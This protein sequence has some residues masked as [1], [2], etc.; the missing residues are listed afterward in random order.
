[1]FSVLLFDRNFNPIPH[2]FS[3]I[4]QRYGASAET[5]FDSAEIEVTGNTHQMQGLRHWLRY[6]VVIRNP[7]HNAVWA[8][9]VT[10]VSYPKGSKKYSLTLDDMSN[11]LAVAHSE[12]DADGNTLSG[13]T[14]YADNLESQ[15]KYGIKDLLKAGGDLDLAM[16]T[17]QRDNALLAIGEP[18][19]D[20]DLLGGG[21]EAGQLRCRG[22]GNAFAWRIFNQPGGV[23][24]HQEN[25]NF[26]HL[27][28]WGIVASETMAFGVGGGQKRLHRL[29]GAMEALRKDDVIIVSGA[30][31]GANNGTFT[32]AE[33]VS[34]EAQSYTGTDISSDPADDFMSASGGLGFVRSHELLLVS[35]FVAPHTGNNRYYF[36]HTE[37]GAGHITVRPATVGTVSAGPS[38]T[39]QQGHS[40]ALTGVSFV[41]EYPGAAITVTALGVAVAQS[42]TLPVNAPFV[43]AE[44]WVRL[45]RVGNPADS[46]RATIY[47]NGASVPSGTTLE[48]VSLLGST[49][50]DKNMT[51][52]KFTFTTSPTLAFGAVYWLGI[53]RTGTNSP[54]DYY[55]LDLDT[56]SG[57]G[58]GFLK[59]WN[60]S[61]WVDRAASADMPF[62]IWAKRETTEQ[63]R[64]IY[65]A[66]NQFCRDIDIQ[67]AS[68]RFSRMYRDSDL[69]AQQEMAKLLRAGVLGGRRLLARISPDRVLHISEE[70]TYNA[71]NAPIFTEDGE[72]VDVTGQPYEPGRLPVGQWIT[73]AGE[74]PIRAG[75]F[76]ERAEYDA[77]A[78]RYTQ[79]A[80]KGAV[81]PF[82]VVRLI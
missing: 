59:L 8:G 23:V 71:S 32:V 34:Q 50:S 82:D 33:G 77:V 1:M 15:S 54:T 44:A 13:L 16:A 46:V 78:G 66:S 27:L 65:T 53:D 56:D 10:G 60:G 37:T 57:F 40:V 58:G 2:S 48:S 49:I 47:T 20:T 51:W 70:P 22:L 5:G 9:L 21:D 81:D 4:P 76:I 69:D 63:I 75:K 64:D 43:V 38:V 14:P 55:V 31:N 52:V 35:G 19:E 41:Q 30:A 6:Y 29:L 80:P 25:G 7:N 26:E 3:L 42:F 67:V 18:P 61:A 24:R 17:A 45:K 36:V 12:T 72:L 62:Q 39:L 73:L 79:L 28:G 68:G 74:P 11:R